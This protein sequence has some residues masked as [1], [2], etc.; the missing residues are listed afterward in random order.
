MTATTRHQPYAS[1]RVAQGPHQTVLTMMSKAVM[2]NSERPRAEQ[3]PERSSLS[4]VIGMIPQ[5]DTTL[6]TVV[7]GAK[8]PFR[9]G[10]GRSPD[11]DRLLRKVER[12]RDDGESEECR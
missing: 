8:L 2:G 5:A 7:S 9:S 4:L 12:S 3:R 11:R 10:P 6:S 1:K